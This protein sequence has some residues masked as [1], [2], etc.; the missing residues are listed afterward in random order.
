V[1]AS[2]SQFSLPVNTTAIALP[3]VPVGVPSTL[4]QRRPDIAAAERRIAAANKRIG[5][6]RTAWFPTISLSA[7]GGY[8]SDEF[9][10]LLSA[11]N[12]FWAVGPALVTT[13]FDAG[14]RQ[15]QVDSARAATEEAGS[16]YRAVVLGAFEQVE[17]NLTIIDGLGSALEDQRAAA[18]AARYTE[19]LSLERYKQGAIGYLDVVVA[20]TASLQAQR[21][22]LDLQTRQLSANVGLIKALGGGWSRAE[23]L[24][25]NR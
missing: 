23:E 7:Q 1:G 2:A 12:L 3:G 8:Q 17:D 5:V 4:L 10:N 19:N 9:A 20:Q 18:E 16:K 13:L 11:P 14:A 24:S 25:I 22:V 15:A 6:A 21:S